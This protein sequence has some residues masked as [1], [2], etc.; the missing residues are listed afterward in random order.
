M[1]VLSERSRSFVLYL[2]IKGSAVGAS[3][4]YSDKRSTKLTPKA[5][6]KKK[7]CSLNAPLVKPRRVPKEL[8]KS[9][10]P[11]EPGTIYI[12]FRPS[13]PSF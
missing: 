7:V 1:K 10:K 8:F 6:H 3:I 13:S 2:R 9:N 4:I 5:Q 11:Y 12:T